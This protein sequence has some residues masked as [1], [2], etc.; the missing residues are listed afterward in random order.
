MS[1][2]QVPEFNFA[3][4]KTQGTSGNFKSICETVKKAVTENG[5]VQSNCIHA[6]TGTCGNGVLDYNEDCDYSVKKSG[7]FDSSL[8]CDKSCKFK[9]GKQ[10]NRYYR[11]VKSVDKKCGGG[12]KCKWCSRSDCSSQ[13]GCTWDTDLYQCSDGSGNGID[14]LVEEYYVNDCCNEDGTYVLPSDTST[15]QPGG[16]CEIGGI[17][18]QGIRKGICVNGK[19]RDFCRPSKSNFWFQQCVTDDTDRCKVKCKAGTY[20]QCAKETD[21]DVQS[22]LPAGTVCKHNPYSTCTS[23]GVCKE[24]SSSAPATTTPPPPV[25]TTPPPSVDCD[26]RGAC[27]RIKKKAGDDCAK[28]AMLTHGVIPWTINV[29]LMVKIIG[30]TAKYHQ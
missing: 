28:W 12:K 6:L 23:A 1:Y 5:W 25:T 24:V 3:D 10:C 13:N 19:C 7:K 20:K 8:W 26:C 2:T 16:N 21:D 14:A 30:K 17:T 9:P 18:K 22:N 4:I 29:G 27:I 11:N 15:N